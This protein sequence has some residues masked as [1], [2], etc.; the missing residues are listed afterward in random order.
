MRLVTWSRPLVV[1]AGSLTAAVAAASEPL[2]LSTQI[3]GAVQTYEVRK[4]DT[5]SL[6][7]ARFGVD[8]AAMAREN[9]LDLRRPLTPGQ[10]LT[11][12]NRHVVPAGGG[13][14]EV[15]LNV[16]QRML[17]R[18]VGPGV[19]WAAPAGLGRADWPTPLGPFH[20]VAREQHP[21][22]DVPLSIQAEMRRAGRRV[23]TRVPPGPDNPL[24][25]YWIGLSFGSLGIHGTPAPASIYQ[26]ATHGC[27]RLHADDVERLYG[28][29]AVGTPGA[30]VYAP[31]LLAATAEGIFL[32]V[33]R[34]VYRRGRATL[35]DVRSAAATAGLADRIDWQAAA[36]VMARQEGVAR[37]IGGPLHPASR[38]LD[39]R[40][41]P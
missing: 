22:W 3:V 14:V 21:T 19:S 13:G 33:H 23:V 8:R 29:V 26:F 25:D 41:H 2:R 35:A 40:S 30:S 12:D 5:L 10:R 36:D 4:G 34:D 9:V 28:E 31:V 1:L 39:R 17:F 7:G 38:D 6:I 18:M 27:I 20:V 11:I 16:A 32:E 15:V 24:G 37:A